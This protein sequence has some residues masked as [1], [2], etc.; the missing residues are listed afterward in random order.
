MLYVDT[1]WDGNHGIG[2]FSREVLS[3]L[4]I[5]WRPLKGSMAPSSPLDVLNPNRLQLA[6]SDTVFSPGYNAGFS[7]ARQIITLHDVIHLAISSESGFAKRAYYDRVIKPAVTKA[8]IVMTDSETSRTAIESWI[9]DSRIEVINVGNGC[10]AAF[11]RAGPVAEQ[12]RGAFVYVGNLKPHKNVDVLFQ[13]LRL[14]PSF[15]LIVVSSDVVDVARRAHKAGVSSQVVALS[16]VTDEK[17][18]EIYRS[19]RGLL[20]PSQLEGFGLPAAE[21]LSCG[22]PV[23]YWKGCASVAEI[24]GEAGP[25]VSEAKSGQAWAD[26]MTQMADGTFG[27]S[28]RSYDWSDVAQGINA[29]LHRDRMTS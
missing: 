25:A 5:P 6:A 27:P 20:F 26:A 15:S 28:A 21:A 2:R 19:S 4:D 3:R 24:V 12:F 11:T 16:G 14:A 17:L 23:A 29:V 22:I 9:G 13:A 10:S 7:R 8:G 1:R 18:A